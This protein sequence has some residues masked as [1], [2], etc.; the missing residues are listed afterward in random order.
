LVEVKVTSPRIAAS[1]LLVD[2][3]SSNLRRYSE[4]THRHARAWLI[5]VFDQADQAGLILRA[6]EQL[7]QFEDSSLVISILRPDEIG[8]LTIPAELD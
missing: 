3:A 7:Q 8:K 4:I 1:R 5:I 6:S 2:P